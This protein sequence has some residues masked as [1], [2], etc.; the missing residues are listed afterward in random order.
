MRGTRKYRL[1]E[2][3]ERLYSSVLKTILTAIYSSL[4]SV[5]VRYQCREKSF[6]VGRLVLRDD[7]KPGSDSYRRSSRLGK[8][9]A[10][11]KKVMRK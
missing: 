4:I 8:R 6:W 9:L 3:N 2:M 10:K 1:H 11:D 7:N 5:M